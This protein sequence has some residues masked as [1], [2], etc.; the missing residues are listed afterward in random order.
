MS[1]PLIIHKLTKPSART[2]RYNEEFKLSEQAT[3]AMVDNGQW[4]TI[5][6][7]GQLTMVDNGQGW[8]MDNDGQ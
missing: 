8:T 7:C 6:N 2:G 4:S 3:K 5:D 1:G